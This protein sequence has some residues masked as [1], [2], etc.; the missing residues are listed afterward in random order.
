MRA[1]VI[2]KMKD[3]SEHTINIEGDEQHEFY[4][5]AKAKLDDLLAKKADE[6]VQGGVA[7]PTGWTDI[8]TW[9]TVVEDSSSGRDKKDGIA[10]RSPLQKVRFDLLPIAPLVEVAKVF[11]FGAYNYG[12]RNWEEGFSWSRCIGSIWRHF[13][14]WLLGED[15]D[16][17]SGLH[18]LAH[19][20]ANCLFLMQYTITGR[21]T[22]DRQKA[23]AKFTHELFQPVNAEIKKKG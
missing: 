13:T 21:G 20:I 23:S 14:K 7:L 9:Q 5:A 16:D 11:T 18:H 17:E 6:A 22:D 1:K 15:R 8:E 12:D 10:I 4:E 19:V 2:F 3:R